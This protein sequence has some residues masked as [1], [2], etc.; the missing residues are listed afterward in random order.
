MLVETPP[1]EF[2]FTAA[3]DEPEII[4][5]EGFAEFPLEEVPPAE[6]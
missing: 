4:V 2:A 3:Y 6:G 1:M 5:V